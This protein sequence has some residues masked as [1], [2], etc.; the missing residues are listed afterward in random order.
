VRAGTP[1]QPTVGAEAGRFPTP[2]ASPSR[3]PT[4]KHWPMSRSS[5]PSATRTARMFLRS[6]QSKLSQKDTMSASKS[7]TGRRCS[8]ASG[9][10]PRSP[11]SP[12]LCSPPTPCPHQPRLRFPLPVAYRAAS[13][14]AMP[15]G[16][17][18]RAP[19]HASCLGDNSLALR[20][21]GICRGEAR[22]S[23]VPGPSSSC[24]L[25]SNTPPDTFPSSPVC[26]RGALLPSME[27][28]TLGIR[29]DDRFRG[30]L[31]HGPHARVPP[32][33]RPPF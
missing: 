18:T 24:V 29:E 14:C 2:T 3:P 12:L 11:T 27:S 6:V 28:S 25:W 26:R 13:A 23:Q 21:A 22:A 20:E 1:G 5:T 17:T 9:L 30:R 33:R 10:P 7:H 4:C 31:A 8:A 32:L 19:A 15:L 16:S